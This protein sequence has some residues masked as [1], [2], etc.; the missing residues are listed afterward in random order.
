MRRA[1]VMLPE[2]VQVSDMIVVLN[3][4]VSQL[5]RMP[6]HAYVK[7]MRTGLVERGAEGHDQVRGI[8]IY[9]EGGEADD[10]C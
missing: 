7:R 9:V 5:H 4:L 6:K 3:S 2:K 8:E 1:W 10:T